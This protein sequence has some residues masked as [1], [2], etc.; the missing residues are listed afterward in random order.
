MI[1]WWGLGRMGG[2]KDQ[3]TGWQPPWTL[4]PMCPWTDK[5]Q[6]N[7]VIHPSTHLFIYSFNTH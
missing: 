7:N 1:R 3:L 4:A 5:D 2:G 6:G